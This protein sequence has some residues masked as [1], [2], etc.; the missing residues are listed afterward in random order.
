MLFYAE[1]SWDVA[2]RYP[3]WPPRRPGSLPHKGLAPAVIQLCGLDPLRDE[4]LLYARVLEGEG[5]KTKVTT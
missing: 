5:V 1:Y 2:F 3:W 4:G